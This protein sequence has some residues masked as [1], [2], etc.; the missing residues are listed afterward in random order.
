[1]AQRNEYYGSWDKKAA[2]LDQELDEEMK[3]EEEQANTALGRTGEPEGPPVA[4]AKQQREE[5]SSHSAEKKETIKKMEDREKIVT[6]TGVSE[7]VDRG[8]AG[9]A[10]R[11][12]DCSKC[13]YVIPQDLPILKIFIERCTDFEL[14]LEAPLL[15]SS[16]ELWKSEKVTLDTKA[17]LGS[18][19]VD[20]V[21]QLRLLVLQ[22]ADAPATYHAKTND[23]TMTVG[24]ADPVRVEDSSDVQ[25][26]AVLKDKTIR[27]EPLLRHAEGEFPVF[28]TASGKVAAASGDQ[29]SDADKAEQKR[30]A[31]NEA[32]KNSDFMQAAAYY[33]EALAVTPSPV[34]YAN[35]AQCWLKLGDP[36]KALKDSQA[37]VDLDGSFVKGHFRKGLALR[38]LERFGEAQLALVEAEKLDPKN[39]QIQE[40]LKFVLMM[41]Q[42]RSAAPS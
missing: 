5:L 42:R 2:A 26:L 35:R 6:G 17:P 39:Q 29:V 36:E 7:S 1:M 25:M 13:R 19:Q 22:E 40:A 24:G 15:T 37:C 8:F 28:P 16:A 4:R 23:F 38:A 3:R 30:R 41:A 20:D 11:F 21:S 34:V 10:I 12:K 18:L 31:G 33:A 27:S 9:K 32:F 14:V